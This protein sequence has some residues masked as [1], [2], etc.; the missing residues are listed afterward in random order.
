MRDSQ[1]RVPHQNS[2]ECNEFSK[3][4]WE[5]ST[6]VLASSI[7]NFVVAKMKGTGMGI[8]G[9]RLWWLNLCGCLGFGPVC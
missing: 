8:N 3:V 6:I 1:V 2:I 7:G 5:H 9:Q 4:I